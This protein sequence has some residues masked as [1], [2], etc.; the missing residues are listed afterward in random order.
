MFKIA[1]S[2]SSDSGNPPISKQY[3]LLGGIAALILIS[4]LSSSG[5]A[6]VQH[7]ISNCWEGFI[8][9]IADPVIGLDRLAAIVAIGLLSAK[10]ARGIWISVSFLLAAFCGQLIHLCQLNLPGAEIVLAICTITFGVILVL[11]TPNSRLACILIGAISAIA[12]LSQGYVDSQA[13]L[14]AEMVTLVLYVIGVTLTQT[15]IVMS[16]RKIGVIISK[17]TINQIFPKTIRWIG[18]TFSAVGIVFLGNAV[19]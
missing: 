1:L 5:G 7:T 8:W 10:F 11:P 17:A 16:A 4:L 18:L 2:T 15:V 19:I 6:P 3:R 9:G 12:G 14:G 13:I